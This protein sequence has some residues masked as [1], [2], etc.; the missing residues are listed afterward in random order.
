LRGWQAGS[1]NQ[2]PR[3]KA[4]HIRGPRPFVNTGFWTVFGGGGVCRGVGWGHI[5]IP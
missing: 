1:G 5:I 4:A 3:A 2:T